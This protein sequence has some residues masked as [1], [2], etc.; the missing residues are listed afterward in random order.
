[1]AYMATT[2]HTSTCARGGRKE[3]VVYVYCTEHSQLRVSFRAHRR[4]AEAAE[5]RRHVEH[6]DRPERRELPDARLHQEERDAEQ[7]TKMAYGTR[8][9]PTRHAAVSTSVP[10]CTSAL[11]EVE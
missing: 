7:T 3:Y 1:M 10:Y 9:A 2:Q 6:A 4:V 11:H 5:E 8:N